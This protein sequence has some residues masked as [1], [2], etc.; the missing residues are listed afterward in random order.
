MLL[1]IS[2]ILVDDDLRR[3]R[4]TIGKLTWRDGRVTA[5]GV[6]SGVKSNQQADLKSA[7]GRTFQTEVMAALLKHPVL[8]AAARPRRFSNLLLSCTSSG[9]HY[10]PHIDNALMSKGRERFRSDLSF[11]LFLT[12]PSD[13]DG[14]EL[15]VHTA[16]ASYSA[17]GEAGDLVLYPSSCIHEVAPV[18]KGERIVCAGWIESL[19]ADV[20]QRELLFDLENLRSSLRA[21]LPAQSAERLTLDKTIAN[22]LRMWAQP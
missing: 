5:G 11:T 20:A 2:E 8:T 10:G 17:K 14:G 9:D 19:I 21:S 6:A 3:L 1:T 15:V 7:K 13:Y 22:L 4:Q 12:P 18:Q 16:S